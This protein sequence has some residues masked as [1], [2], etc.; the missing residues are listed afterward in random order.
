MFM[1]CAELLA[2]YERAAGARASVDAACLE[3]AVEAAV[4]AGRVAGDVHD[5]AAQLLYQMARL[6]PF[7]N[8][9]AEVT[10]TAV[11]G[12]YGRN[13]WHVTIGVADQCFCDA[14]AGRTTLGS[15]RDALRA[16]ALRAYD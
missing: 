10:I 3:A 9:N 15:V 16:A 5:S 2:L 12:F 8:Y 4:R 6:R 14:E 11:E 13:G 1:S 7:P